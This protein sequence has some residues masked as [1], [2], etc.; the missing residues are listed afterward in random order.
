MSAIAKQI[1]SI[2]ITLLEKEGMTAHLQPFLLK[3]EPRE[4]LYEDCRLGHHGITV[5]FPVQL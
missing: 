2:Y 1:A 5:Q 4:I 3:S